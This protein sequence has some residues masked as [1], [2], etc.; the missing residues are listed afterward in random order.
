SV[1]VYDAGAPRNEPAWAV[2][3]FPGLPD[4]SPLEL[5]RR[6]QQQAL[7]AGAEILDVEVSAARGTKGDFEV[8]PATGD[9]VRARRIVL[10]YGL[11]DYVPDI[12]GIDELYGTS[13]FHCPDCDG[14]A[15]AGTRIG[16]IGWDRYTFNI[17]LYLRHFSDA[18]TLLTHGHG[19]TP[20][21]EQR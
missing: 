10:A 11:R 19:F 1:T 13:V 3:G 6:L 8:S 5:R 2:H 21:A 14:P 12:P 17:A 15:V 18:V 16:V 7:G 9:V 20:T 4:P